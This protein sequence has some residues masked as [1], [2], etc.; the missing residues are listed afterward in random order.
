MMPSKSSMMQTG[1]VD[2]LTSEE[3]LD[4]LAYLRS[5]GNPDH[6]LFQ[7]KGIVPLWFQREETKAASEKCGAESGKSSDTSFVCQ[8]VDRQNAESGFWDSGLIC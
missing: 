1:L 5:G 4:F 2:T 6:E 8:H 3:A 7:K